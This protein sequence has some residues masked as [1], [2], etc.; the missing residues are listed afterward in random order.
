MTFEDIT[1]SAQEIKEKNRLA[2][3]EDILEIKKKKMKIL[4]GYFLKRQM[5]KIL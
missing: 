5:M 4:K 3:Y 1:K 2:L